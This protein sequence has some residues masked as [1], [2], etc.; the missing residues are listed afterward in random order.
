V[1]AAARPGRSAAVVAYLDVEVLAF[2]ADTHAGLCRAGVL[3]DVG[4]ALLN[5]A[6][7]GEVERRW[8]WPPLAIDLEADREPGLLRVFDK[9]LDVG[10]S[11]LWFERRVGF[12]AQQADHLPHF[13]ERSPCCRLHGLERLLRPARVVAEELCG[14][15]GLDSDDADRVGDDVV[16]LARDPAA[17]GGHGLARSSLALGLEL[18]GELVH[19]RGAAALAP[20]RLADEPGNEREDDDSERE[21]AGSVAR[22][23]QGVDEIRREQHRERG[24]S[25]ALP[26]VGARRVGG[27]DR[28][29]ERQHRT[30]PPRGQIVD[31]DRRRDNRR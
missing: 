13:A 23:T 8:E 18:S 15:I 2:V 24:D 22:C 27:D 31:D 11:R 29:V 5:D 14:G 10:D 26:R 7:G 21:I 17:L 6:E 12:V 4:Q 28:A 9:P 1:T 25:V 20:Q 3:A 16:Q 19:R 30:V